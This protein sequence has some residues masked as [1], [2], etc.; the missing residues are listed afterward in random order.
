MVKEI[1][2]KG[3]PVAHVCTL[4]PVAMMTGSNRVV[5][6]RGIAHPLGDPDLGTNA[7]KTLRRAIVEKALEALEAKITE[8][9]L[10]TLLP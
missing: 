7:E 3:I 5:A 8:Q 6:A 4:T 1:E 10:F 2:K 9:K